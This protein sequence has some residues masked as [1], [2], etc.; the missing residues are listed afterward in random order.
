MI[1]LLGCLSASMQDLDFWIWNKM[2]P[3]CSEGGRNS[4]C[5]HFSWWTFDDDEDETRPPSNCFQLLNSPTYQKFFLFSNINETSELI[6]FFE[7]ER[8][9]SVTLSSPKP[10]RSYGEALHLVWIRQF[11]CWTVF[12]PDYEE[13]DDFGTTRRKYA[14]NPLRFSLMES[15][16]MVHF[17]ETYTAFNVPLFALRPIPPTWNE[18]F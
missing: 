17:A 5:L 15:A 2:A 8:S 1:L 3:R 12:R 16:V 9:S 7:R 6:V 14:M 13:Y 11:Q 18:A 10:P 4:L